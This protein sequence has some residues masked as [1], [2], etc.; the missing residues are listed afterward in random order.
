MQCV[1]RLEQIVS[2]ADLVEHLALDKIEEVLS[3]MAR[4]LRGIAGRHMGDAAVQTSI[5][6]AALQNLVD[7]LF[8]V[9]AATTPLARPR[10]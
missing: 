6:K 7:S 1:A 5:G 10:D 4:Q 3:L 2:V 9:N 8:R